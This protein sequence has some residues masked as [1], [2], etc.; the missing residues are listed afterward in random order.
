MRK[1]VFRT[2][3]VLQVK[4]CQPESLQPRVRTQNHLL[5]FSEK[6]NISISNFE[7]SGFHMFVIRNLWASS[8]LIETPN[9]CLWRAWCSEWPRCGFGATPDD[10][11]WLKLLENYE[12]SISHFVIRFFPKM[13][14]MGRISVG[15]RH[16]YW[17]TASYTSHLA[18][19]KFSGESELR[20]RNA[21]VFMG[22]T[23]LL[24]ISWFNVSMRFEHSGF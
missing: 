7:I 17:F 14:S 24:R 10:L 23:H 6:N 20:S 3:G 18:P 12:T 21:V 1:S 4:T 5:A 8:G 11:E 2:V 9:E 13:G 22:R 15:A 19:V 16:R